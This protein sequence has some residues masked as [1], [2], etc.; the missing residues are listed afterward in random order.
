MTS[1]EPPNPW[2]RKPWEKSGPRFKESRSIPQAR[3]QV[4]VQGVGEPLEG[5]KVYVFT[6]S[7]GYIGLNAVSND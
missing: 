3:T 4:N 7:G 1:T 2:D 6:E 5:I